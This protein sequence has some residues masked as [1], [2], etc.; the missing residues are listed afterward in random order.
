MRSEAGRAPVVV[1][2][3]AGPG[4]GQTQQAQGM[5][6]R[7]GVEDHVIVAGVVVGQQAGE[8][9][10]RGNLGRACTGELL[11]HGVALRL[12][13]P[14]C[15]LVQHT[16]TVVFGSHVRVDIKHRQGR[17]AGNGDG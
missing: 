6:R 4:P 17:C 2:Q 10:E 7:C 15:H 3:E 11:L 1:L 13:R 14:G 16:P 9:I 12:G 8:F 5:S